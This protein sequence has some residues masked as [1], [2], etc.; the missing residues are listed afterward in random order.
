MISSSFNIGRRS[1]IK[2]GAALAVPTILP[3]TVF[4]ANNK[5]NLA[6]VGFNSMGFTDLNHCAHGNNVVALCDVDQKVL[7]KGKKKYPNAKV[8][9]D[10]RKMLTEMDNQIDAVGIGTP[11]HTHFAITAMAMGM[12]KHVFVEKPLAHSVSEVNALKKL[13]T[14]KQVVTTMGNQGHAW[15]GAFMIKEWYEAGLIGEVREVVCWTDRP[16]RGY[17]FRMGDWKG[18]PE[19]T[20]VPNHLDW[21]LWKGPVTKDIPYNGTFHPKFWRGWWDFGLGGLGDIGCH[22]I[23]APYWALGLDQP[24][25]IEVEMDGEPNPFCTPAGSIVTYHFPARGKQPPV[26]VKW[27]EG[28]KRPPIPPEITGKVS[29]DGGMFMLGSKGIIFHNGMRPKGVRLYPDDFWQEYRTNVSKRVPKTLKRIRGGIHG[30]WL[31]CIR[32]GGT[33]HSDFSYTA[34]LTDIIIKGT[35]AVRTGKGIKVAPDG[36]IS[37]NPQAEALVDVPARKG[38]RLEDL[39]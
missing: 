26:K 28:P 5:I 12:G 2:G 3:H 30:H 15:E 33:A 7:D 27:F 1:L 18:Y 24:E 23:D 11:D 8:Y 14:E 38:W 36:T 10:F 39:V 29:A 25:R 20:P 4:G 31:D 32:Y 34:P 22:T 13:A 19:A 9:T 6:W 37:G 21:D 17:G 35:L 16:A